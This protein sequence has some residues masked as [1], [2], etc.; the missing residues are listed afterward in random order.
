MQGQKGEVRALHLASIYLFGCREIRDAIISR[1]DMLYMPYHMMSW[2]DGGPMIWFFPFMGL[3][4][5]GFWLI[6]VIIAYLVYR[7]AESRGMNGLLWAVLVLLPGAGVLFFIIYLFARGTAHLPSGA[8]PQRYR[9][10]EEILDERYARGEL[11][12]EQYLL[13]RDDLSRPAKALQDDEK[14]LS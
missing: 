12:R 4:A 10:P 1:E 2:W 7:D 8:L 6:F 11:T 5:V 13:M 9:A 3:G 14:D